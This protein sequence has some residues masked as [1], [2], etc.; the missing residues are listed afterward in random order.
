MYTNL[1]FCILISCF[2]DMGNY[3]EQ[4]QIQYKLNWY[5]ANGNYRMQLENYTKQIKN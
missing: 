2:N 1:K 4:I 3:S 5:N